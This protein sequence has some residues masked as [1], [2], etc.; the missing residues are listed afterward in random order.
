MK[1]GKVALRLVMSF[2]VLLLVGG[3]AR[4]QESPDSGLHSFAVIPSIS[5]GALAGIIRLTGRT[6]VPSQ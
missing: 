2:V 4:A 1:V 3:A 6:M 5:M